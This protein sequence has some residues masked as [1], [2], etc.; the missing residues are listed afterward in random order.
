MAH[1]SSNS[2]VVG[3]VGRTFSVWNLLSEEVKGELVV[4][5]SDLFLVYFVSLLLLFRYER[6]TSELILWSP[7]IYLLALCEVFLV[8]DCLL[9]LRV[10][11]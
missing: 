4:L 2:V 6:Y 11:V 3:M 1:P 7:L 8:L 10:L 5:V 9:K